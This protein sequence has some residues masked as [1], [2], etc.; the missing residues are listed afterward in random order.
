MAMSAA[1]FSAT[2]AQARRRFLDAA[3]ER[4]AAIDVYRHP[5]QGAG[6]AYA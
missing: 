4:S 6:T 2:Y 1:F 5:R 3:R